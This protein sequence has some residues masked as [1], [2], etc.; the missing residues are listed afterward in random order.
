MSK[1]INYS[2]RNSRSLKGYNLTGTVGILRKL[3][4]M[5]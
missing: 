4:Q 5:L 2:N 1:G 3:E